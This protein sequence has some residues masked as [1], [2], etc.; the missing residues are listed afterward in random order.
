MVVLAADLVAQI[1]ASEIAPEH[2]EVSDT[3]D[4]CGAKFEAIIVSSKFDGLPLL[5]RQQLVNEAIK[6]E[7]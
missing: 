6:E 1:N 2:C 5:K 4:G 3:S 7:M